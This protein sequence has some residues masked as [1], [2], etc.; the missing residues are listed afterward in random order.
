M[1]RISKLRAIGIDGGGSHTRFV[2]YDEKVGVLNSLEINSPG[3]YHL[4]GAEGVKKIFKE[5]IK[6][7]SSNSYF[8]TIGAGLSG[9]DRPTDKK[10]IS[11]IFEEIGVKDFAISNDGVTALWGATGGVGILMISG[12]GSIIVGRNSKGKVYRAGGWGYMFDEYCSG[13]WFSN[14]AAMAALNYRDRLGPFTTLES[15]LVNFYGIKSIDDIVYL[16]YS[17][18]DKAKIA[19]AAKVV[20]QE[21][22]KGDEISMKIVKNG[23]ENALNMIS[24]V[25][26]RCGFG[27]RF[28]FSYIGG[29]FNSKYFLRR[30]ENAFEATFPRAQFMH[31]KFGA[32]VGAALMA[33]DLWRKKDEQVG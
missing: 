6:R 25:A 26:R 2:L 4:I 12:T 14:R 22:Q 15:V 28:T 23:V 32:D 17:D 18:F 7:V 9:V 20:L 5:G 1:E 13:F 8:D 16:Y 19:S 27:G 33:I 21:A 29:L 31:P 10:I 24:V 3:N 11:E 30:V